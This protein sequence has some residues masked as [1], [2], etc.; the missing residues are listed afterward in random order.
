MAVELPTVTEVPPPVGGIRVTHP[1]FAQIRASRV[2]GSTAL[3]GSDFRHQHY[4]TITISASYLD[5]HLSND[6]PHDGKE[7]IE[8]AMSEAQWATFVSS[9]NMGGGVQCTLTHQNGKPIPA[10]PDPESRVQQFGQELKEGLAEHVQELRA[11]ASQI[12]EATGKKAQAELARRLDII[13]GNFPSNTSFVAE[14]FDE[15]VEGTVEKAK[16]E[17]NAHLTRAVQAAGLSALSAES[18]QNLLTHDKTVI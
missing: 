7:L 15:H 8:V 14:Q 4:L 3:Y 6:W 5:R 9:L 16:I 13:A 1:A 10:L 18:V 2:S 11:I 17:I 12:R